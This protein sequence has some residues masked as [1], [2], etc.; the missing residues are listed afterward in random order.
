MMPGLNWLN[1]MPTDQD[2]LAI[3]DAPIDDDD[4]TIHVLRGLKSAF[5][6]ISAAI[7][8]RECSISFKELHDKLVEHEGFL[9]REVANQELVIIAN[10]MHKHGNNNFKPRKGP[11]NKS[12]RYN[13]SQ[14]SNNWNMGSIPPQNQ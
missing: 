4:L 5:K 2:E 12:S 3:I 9:K 7:R 8:S 11:F 10:Y 13:N 14:P 1:S 6:D